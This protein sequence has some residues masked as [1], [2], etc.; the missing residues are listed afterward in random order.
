MLW[1]PRISTEADPEPTSMPEHFAFSLAVGGVS[2]RAVRDVLLFIDPSKTCVRHAHGLLLEGRRVEIAVCAYH[3]VRK[4]AETH[5]IDFA[6]DCRF[7]FYEHLVDTAGCSARHDGRNW[8]L[9]NAALTCFAPA[10]AS[11]FVGLVVAALTSDRSVS[12]CIFHCKHGRHRS[13]ATAFCF[14]FLL[15]IL[16]AEV[17]LEIPLARLCPCSRCNVC[18]YTL[19]AYQIDT[20]IEAIMERTCQYLRSA[21]CVNPIVRSGLVE[22][23]E[24]LDYFNIGGSPRDRTIAS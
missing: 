15:T 7:M 2:P 5:E 8:K 24:F 10:F 19:E 23:Y 9:L 13:V 18:G 12:R 14:A 17:S 20:W 3:E 22:L 1:P 6:T 16:G 4:K 21:S 11:A